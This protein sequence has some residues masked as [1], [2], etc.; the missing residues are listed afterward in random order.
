MGSLHDE[1]RIS[2]RNLLTV[3]TGATVA[4]LA[5]C[6]E[7]GGADNDGDASA[8]AGSFFVM[9][10]FARHI[11]GDR[12]DVSDLVPIGSHGDDYEP[13]PGVVLEA[14]EADIFIYIDGFQ[15]W[16]DNLASTLQD[17]YPEMAVI[18]AAADIDYIEGHGDR[19][20]DPHFWMDPQRAIASIQTIRDGFIEVDPEGE[21]DYLE[22]ADQLIGQIEEVDDTLVDIFQRRSRDLLV[23]AS[24]NSFG[25]WSDRFG[26]EIYSPI[27]LSPDA[28]PTPRARAEV[29]E[30]VD[31]HD[32]EYLLYDKYESTLL[33]E[34][35]SNDSGTDLLPLSPIEATTQEQYDDGWGYVEHMREINVPSLRTALGVHDG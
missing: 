18:D 13:S 3:G 32:I 30:I 21:S 28:E 11:A 20:L 12:L 22:G 2:R 8:V 6:L 23:V 17:D 7:R 9:Y 1:Y 34:Q 35:L 24:H 25:Y 19:P 26:I 4:A 10:D 14:A 16:A 27:G 33:A 29:S 5:G 31:E 15:P